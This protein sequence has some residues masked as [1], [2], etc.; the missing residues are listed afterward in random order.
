[1]REVL[2]PVVLLVLLMVLDARVSPAS[3][4]E[5]RNEWDTAW[6]K[7]YSEWISD[8]VD[9]EV[10]QPA[11]LSVDC[12]DLCY[13]VRAIFARNNALPFLASDANG[14]KI[15]HFMGD[16]D[17]RPRA[18]KWFQDRRLRD[19]LVHVIRHVTTKSFPHDTYPVKLVPET[20]KP[21]LV[22]YE[23]LIASHAAFIGRI[24]AS[25]IIPI[26]FFEGS[27]P[28]ARKF[29]RTT[30]LNVYIYSPGVP[31]GHSAIASWNWP[32]N[33]KGRW[34]YIPDAQM[35]YYSTEIYQPAFPY[36]T[37][38][39]QA[40]NRIIKENTAVSPSQPQG[41]LRQ[42]VRY[43]E[44][45]IRFRAQLV[46]KAEALLAQQGADFRSQ[47]FDYT[48]NTDSRDERLYKL[49]RSLW[50]ALDEYEISREEFFNA[51]QSIPITITPRLPACNLL[52]L[53]ICVDRHWISSNAY[54]SPEVRWGMR[55][56]QATGQWSF[57]AGR[58]E[59]EVLSWYMPQKEGQDRH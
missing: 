8:A 25:Q 32:V 35:P 11:G 44:E 41:H 43:F 19:F 52:F 6:E 30:I 51:L 42:L 55:W 5:V 36:R 46:E 23:N 20:V 21:G 56:D 22:I 40:L 48:Y 12:A 58:K 18:A 16:F 9:V 28:P 3:V 39:S 50:A 27:V 1:M 38:L 17:D 34:D 24:D 15:G 13:V 49:L 54:A 53:F 26:Q 37:R 10:L 29:K 31:I 14:K 47:Y 7:R 4:W 45:E 2:F 33:R 59:E 57:P